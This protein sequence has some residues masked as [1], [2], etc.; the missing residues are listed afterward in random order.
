MFFSGGLIKT[1]AKDR[2]S[3]HTTEKFDSSLGKFVMSV[4]LPNSLGR[5]RSCAANVNGSAAVLVGGCFKFEALSEVA[6]LNLLTM[7]WAVV[8]PMK[9]RRCGPTCGMLG[10]MCE[11]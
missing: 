2:M 10:G 11:S 9:H 1:K 5:Y 6:F 3:T 7:T 4:D 8:E